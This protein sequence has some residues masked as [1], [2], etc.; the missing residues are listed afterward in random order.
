MN[1]IISAYKVTNTTLTRV[2]YI[3]IQGKVFL[4]FVLDFMKEA[5]P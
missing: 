1:G 3:L 2:Y 4:V 5:E